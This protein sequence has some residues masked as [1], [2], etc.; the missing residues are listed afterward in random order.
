M[1][2]R[3]VVLLMLCGLLAGLPSG[4][5]SAQSPTVSAQLDRYLGGDHEPVA[6]ELAA[7]TDFDDLLKALKRDGPAW[8]AAATASERPRRQLTAA[9]FALEAARAAEDTDWKWVMQVRLGGGAPG[10]LP[11]SYRAPP[12]VSWKAPPL[13]IEWGCAL[14]RSDAVPRPIERIWHLAAISV[15]QRRGDFEFLIG[16]PWEERGNAQDEIEHLA[17]VIKRVPAEPRFALAQA[18]AVEWRTWFPR[19]SRTGRRNL[20]EAMRAFEGM[21]K[22]DAIGAEAALRLGALRLRDRNLRGAIDLFERVEEMTRDRYLI[23]LARYFRGQALERQTRVAEA[24]QAYRGALATIPH[25]TSATMALAALWFTADRQAESSALV[26][27]SV[28]ARPQPLD[29]WRTYAA[30]DD[31]FWPEL[32]ARL[33]AEIRR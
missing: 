32:V 11:P 16:S 19:G 8:I 20:S 21:T 12:A 33:R 5:P 27:A 29:P 17:H 14:M 15:A 1:R 18:I 22:D 4:R 6:A 9:T 2:P 26:E 10:L 7:I 23:Y 25:A 28:S 13:L 3:R 30:A 31:R 24:E